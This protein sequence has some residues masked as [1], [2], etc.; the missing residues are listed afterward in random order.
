MA[1]ESI[2]IHNAVNNVAFKSFGSVELDLFFSIC[3]QMKEKGT[4]E[5]KFSFDDLKRL[6]NYRTKGTIDDFYK[7]LKSV[8]NKL[9]QL[10][11]SYE[12]GKKGERIYTKFVLFTKYKI[13]EKE[14]SVDIAVNK[15]FEYILNELTSNFT[16]FELVEFT[17]LKSSYSK[18][19]FKLL[20]QYNSTGIFNIS[21]N[22]F[23]ERLDIPVSYK[24]CEID[25]RVLKP[26][27]NELK[28]Y[29]RNLKLK[30]IKKGRNIDKLEFIFNKRK[31]RTLGFKNGNPVTADERTFEEIREAGKNNIKE[32]FESL[33]R[34]EQAKLIRKQL[35][36]K[37]N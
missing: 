24:M 23:R 22:D 25:T 32:E 30:K 14:K 35:K 21:I 13:N 9:I 5:I 2:K 1:N 33:D 8:Y 16:R 3:Y 18:Q 37:I 19:M 12:T 29:F 6:S 7:Y 17:K 36:H 31:E 34:S 15:E 28:F 11:F 10:D 27:L 26:I 20:A 4:E